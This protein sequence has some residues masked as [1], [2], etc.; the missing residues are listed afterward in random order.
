MGRVQAVSDASAE[1]GTYT[2][3][4]EKQVVRLSEL[5]TAAPPIIRDAEF[6]DCDVHG[7]AV[8]G[9][10]SHV[11]FEQCGFD[12]PPE[13]LFI[14]AEDRTY[15]GIIGLENVRF[16]RCRFHGVGLLAPAEMVE[17]FSAGLR[18]R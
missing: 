14:P 1:S 5:A 13:A 17:G 16:F 3:Q 18:S 12:A 8:V 7:P 10:I 4:H 11:T 15:V 6:V 9:L 2:V